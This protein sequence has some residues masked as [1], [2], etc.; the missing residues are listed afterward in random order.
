MQ[1]IVSAAQD[2]W[3]GSPQIDWLEA[4]TPRI[5]GE[6]VHTVRVALC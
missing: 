1:G 5:L 2:P 3:Q 6:D 4:G